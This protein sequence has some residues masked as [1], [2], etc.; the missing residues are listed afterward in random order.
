MGVHGGDGNDG[1][2]GN[3]VRRHASAPDRPFAAAGT[4]SH[5]VSA[6]A[7]FDLDGT[8]EVGRIAGAGHTEEPA[9]IEA[10]ADARRL[11][12]SASSAAVL[13]SARLLHGGVGS[14]NFV[15]LAA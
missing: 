5:T 8:G 2:P 12:H 7:S 6:V 11:P 15:D 4:G 9:V 14:G 10:K 1:L 13:R 3:A